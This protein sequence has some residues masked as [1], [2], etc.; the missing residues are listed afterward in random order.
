MQ[1]FFNG[2]SGMT[3]FSKGLDN[4][5]NNISNMN[6][7]GFKGN[8]L[9]IRSLGDGANNY[10]SQLAEA[11]VR[12]ASGDIRQ[13]SSETD[14]AITGNGYF[15]LQSESGEIFYTRAGQFKFNED[16]QLVD[17]ATGHYVMAIN[18][19]GA[20]E[21]LNISEN[22]ILPPEPTTEIKF[23]GNLQSTAQVGAV[24]TVNN[25]V[26]YDATG[27]SHNLKLDFTKAATP[28]N[29]WQ[30]N[31]K[32][33]SNT[34]IGTFQVQF[35]NDSSPSTGFNSSTQSLS[36]GGTTQS[37]VFTIGNTGSLAGATQLTG[38]SDL[39]VFPQ[40]GHAPLGLR[41]L[42][43][44]DDGII[45]FKYANGDTETGQQIALAQ[46]DDPSK[47]QQSSSGLLTSQSSER[48]TIGKPNQELFGTIQGKSLEMSN[49]DLTQEFADILIIQRGYQAS[50]R[51]MSVS[52]DMLEQLYNSTRT[53]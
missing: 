50:S 2:L 10:G 31:I 27:K 29:T 23:V 11:S 37:V 12:L 47:L 32:N 53:K 8:D 49:V 16:N 44:N 46:F 7:P 42:S 48:P 14:L 38:E 9:F 15:I 20:L 18:D 40:D 26:T 45:E 36:L 3:N 22:K 17:S 39:S 5:S 28:S 13:T 25:I 24:H 35:D 51:V 21:R 33:E 52:N 30:V 4:V 6:T 34:V 43:F 19:V 1:S 41:S